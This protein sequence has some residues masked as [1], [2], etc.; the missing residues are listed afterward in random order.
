MEREWIVMRRGGEV[1][2]GWGGG[3]R[4][5]AYSRLGAAERQL[6][7]RNMREA[8]VGEETPVTVAMA[9]ELG[10]HHDAIEGSRQAE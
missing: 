2:C 10:H 8:A 4:R 5:G 7:V 9:P 3:L 6:H 1:M